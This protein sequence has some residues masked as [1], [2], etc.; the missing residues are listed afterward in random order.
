MRKWMT[1]IT[2]IA[3]VSVLFAAGCSNAGT[4]EQAGNDAKT[5][6]GKSSGKVT[7]KINFG[8]AELAKNLVA[9]F[10]KENP[11]IKLEQVPTD[12]NKLMAMIAAG[13]A[14]DIIRVIAATEL[15]NYVI[16]GMALDLTPY[17]E[18]SDVF[19]ADDFLPAVN[20]YK[21]DMA[22]GTQGT[23]PIYGFP[24]DWSQDFTLFYNKKIFEAAGIEPPDTAEPMTWQQLLDL[25]KK[26]T[27][28]E[29]GK[30]SQYG[31]V[32]YNGHTAAN[33]DL[34]LLQLAQTG[35]SIYSE[36]FSQADLT[37][38]EVKEL[39]HYWADAVKSNIGPNP[40]N[41][42]PDWGGTS[43]INGKAAMMIT[44]YW[45]TG[46]LRGD[47]KAKEH[48]DDFSMAPAPVMPGGTR[49]SPTGAAV[50]GIIYSKTQHP[51][52]AWRVFEWFFGGKPADDRARSGWGLPATKSRLEL[53]P[54]A[55][56]FDKASLEFTNNELKFADKF[57]GYN[58]YVS[59]QAAAAIFDKHFT[60]VYFGKDS[61][62]SAADKMTKEMNI[63]I[64][65]GKDIAGAE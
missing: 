48:L 5:S 46:L 25:A 22:T 27:K 23:G 44:G 4:S 6:D 36:D 16:K 29:G 15:P 13:N 51:K 65:E 47:A 42:D 41:Q 32:Y 3:I 58:P 31:L 40:V 12:Y 50:G 38:P 62:D 52:E 10:E 33:Q 55:T 2:A 37:K 17:F 30:V 39:L 8:D 53:M 28:K 57:I 19:K 34:L 59:A 7:I 26:L 24:K 56:N 18:T 43:F 61:V 64:Q 49:M 45:Y 54:N 1:W 11:D 21:Y 63:L 9:E 14:P 20:L 35:K 60:P